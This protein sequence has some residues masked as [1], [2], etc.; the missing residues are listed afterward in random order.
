MSGAWVQ[1][2]MGA[3]TFPG[4]CQEIG[5]NFRF[6][7]HLLFTVSGNEVPLFTSNPNYF[8][9]IAVMIGYYQQ[10]NR[11][12]FSFSGG[13]SSYNGDENAIRDT[14]DLGAVTG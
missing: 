4:P 3:G 10:I 6:V 2:G 11:F 9:D 12:S 5:L 1:V 8:Q 7:N 13:I 14:V